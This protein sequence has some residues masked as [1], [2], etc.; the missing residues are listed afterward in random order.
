MRLGSPHAVLLIL[1]LAAAGCVDV[2]SE[3]AE[4]A[5]APTAPGAGGAPCTPVP[6]ENRGQRVEVGS[7]ARVSSEPRSFSYARQGLAAGTWGYE[8][9]NPSGAAG[10][11]SSFEGYGSIDVEIY[12]A[13]GARILHKTFTRGGSDAANER[14]PSGEPGAWTIQTRIS[15]FSGTISFSITS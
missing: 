3:E 2:P 13:C 10:F 14:L 11:N 6:P 5:D 1:T 12:D 7:T 15:A 8:W 9:L 4:R